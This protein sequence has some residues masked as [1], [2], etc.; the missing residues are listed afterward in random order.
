MAEEKQIEEMAKFCCFSCDFGDSGRC[1]EDVNPCK[2]GIAIETAKRLYEAGYRKQSEGEWERRT[3]I[4]FDD[5]MVGYRCP[6]CNTTWDT[7]TNF[8]PHCERR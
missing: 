4:I 2:C 7:P 1:L 3:F 5:E 8:C 6:C